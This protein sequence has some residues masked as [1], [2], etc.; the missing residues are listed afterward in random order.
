MSF[1]Q[2]LKVTS[3]PKIA[4]KELFS[5][6]TSSASGQ[7]P[8][9]VAPSSSVSKEADAGS[10]M[11]Y[12]TINGAQITEIESMVLS[13]TDILPKIKIMFTDTLGAISGPNYPKND[14]ILSLYIKVSSE[15]LKPIRVDFLI[16]SIKSSQDAILDAD[17][18][19]LS[20]EFIMSGEL[21]IP[22]IYNNFNKA[23]R[24]MGS[25]LALESLAADLD[26]GFSHNDS[27][28]ND[29]MTWINPNRNGIYFINHIARHSYLNDNTFFD[30]FIDK[31][32]HLTMVNVSTQLEVSDE[33]DLTYE[34]RIESAELERNPDSK[35]KS[36]AGDKDTNEAL[37]VLQL[38]NNHRFRGRSE[39]I[40]SFSLQGDVGSILKNKGFKKRIYYY[41]HTLDSDDKFTKFY[42]EPV[43]IKG[44]N[45]KTQLIPAN[46]TLKSN[47]VSKW[48]NIDYGN[49]HREW[50]AAS[51][52]N[53]HNM[54]E[55]SKVRLK[56]ETG[57]I[58]MQVL[59]GSSIKVN[60]FN[61]KA[62]SKTRL[63]QTSEKPQIGDQDL[64]ISGDQG[65][66][67]PDNILS[68][69]Y[70]VIGVKYIYDSSESFKTEFD[71]CRINWISENIID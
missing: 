27:G 57:G 47:V 55:L 70:Y 16:T 1:K 25:K 7:N 71:L 13:E 62:E 69:T 50:N 24:N 28:T 31:F 3:R 41:D 36:A 60:I 17:S 53:D 10:S 12:V 33:V 52:I 68:G 67:I 49:N 44:L 65:D 38:T 61:F 35:N 46:Q 48:M 43:E 42:V 37:A 11:P 4:Q 40:S 23:Y 29:T 15:S 45:K 59:R 22:K 8:F 56:V 51:L 63:S 9:Y 5:A 14:P 6:D 18:M 21:F 66:Q 30:C 26:L 34:Q 39:Y 2:I 54:A 19:G 58:N 64:D 20:A 32:F